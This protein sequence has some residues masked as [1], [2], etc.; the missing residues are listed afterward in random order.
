M[1]ILI[2]EEE[3]TML[4]SCKSNVEADAVDAMRNFSNL[5]NMVFL[6]F[7][8]QKAGRLALGRDGTGWRSQKNKREIQGK[9]QWASVSRKSDP[10]E[11]IIIPET[12]QSCRCQAV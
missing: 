8:A 11:W 2:T 10:P 4:S 6:S 9:R 5:E 3:L 12:G 1:G 7:D